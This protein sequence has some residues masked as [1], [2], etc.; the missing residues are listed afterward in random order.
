M[1]KIVLLTV[2]CCLFVGS[3]QAEGLWHKIG[4]TG[5]MIREAM[6]AKANI[7]DPENYRM[8]LK[9][10]MQAKAAMRGD[11]VDKSKKHWKRIHS[12]ELALK[13]TMQARDY[14]KKARDNSLKKLGRHF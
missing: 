7:L 12:K 10:Q 1:K 2:M 4:N 5:Y 14:A 8:A 11:Y 13:F 6:Q 9:L 3:A